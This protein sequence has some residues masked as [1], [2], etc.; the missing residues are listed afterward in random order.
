MVANLAQ[1]HLQFFKDLLDE[2]AKVSFLGCFPK[3]EESIKTSLARAS[4]LRLKFSPFEEIEKI[5]EKANIA[6]TRNET[7]VKREKYF[8]NFH[9]DVLD[10]N[11]KLKI[12]HKR[13]IFNSAIGYYLDGDFDNAK[14]L[15]EKYLGISGKA[16]AKYSFDK[17][18]DVVSFAEIE[19]DCGDKQLGI[20]ILA[21]VCNLPRQYSSIDDITTY[22]AAKL[23]I[24][25]EV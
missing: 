3:H 11:G 9:R 1:E 13:T 14:L 10:E 8:L 25:N 21:L 5:L 24:A 2:N 20:F 4:F 23:S 12:A 15:L 6:Y 22:A 16:K 19:I 17:F 18:Q 7:A